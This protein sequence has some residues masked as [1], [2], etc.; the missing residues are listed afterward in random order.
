M[1]RRFFTL[2]CRRLGSYNNDKYW[3]F[4]PHGTTICFRAEGVYSHHVDSSIDRITE[5]VDPEDADYDYDGYDTESEM[6]VVS[7]S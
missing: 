3:H 1:T 7:L 5:L 6:S 4:Q 2:P